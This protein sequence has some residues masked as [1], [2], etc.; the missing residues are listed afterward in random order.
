[1]K[2]DTETPPQTML[3]EPKHMLAL[4]LN[5]VGRQMWMKFNQQVEQIG[6]TRAQWTLIAV[7][8]Y[9]PGAT[10]REIADRL[11]VT[12][13]TAGRLIDR[14]CEDGLLE[15][16]QDPE[17]RRCYRIYLL[18]PAKPL[19]RKI[20]QLGEAHT[21]EAFAGLSNTDIATLL[22]LLDVISNNIGAFRDRHHLS[23]SGR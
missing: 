19:L 4:K 14:L 21:Q 2:T 16:R 1:M 22:S 7:V 20:G 6:V 17:D 15:R 11:Q 13:V 9:N 12:E 23:S 10:Q 18:P 8:S 5:V 3:E